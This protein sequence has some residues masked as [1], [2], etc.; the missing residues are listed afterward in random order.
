MTPLAENINFFIVENDVENGREFL[1]HLTIEECK[2]CYV[3]SA[4]QA[5]EKQAEFTH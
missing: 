3:S 2:N 1:N 5:I 4:L